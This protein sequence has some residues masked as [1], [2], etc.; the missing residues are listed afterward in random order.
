[1]TFPGFVDCIY[2]GAPSELTLDN[3]LGDK[4]VISNAKY[5]KLI[6]YKRNRINSVKISSL[7]CG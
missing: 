7:N 4:I 6:C 5:A 1:M 3:G 2:L